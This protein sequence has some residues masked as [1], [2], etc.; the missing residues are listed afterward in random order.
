MLQLL[1]ANQRNAK[2]L[3]AE[4]DRSFPGHA[5]D[6]HRGFA[7]SL[8]SSQAAWEK[9]AEAQCHYEADKNFGGSGGWD[10]EAQCKDRLNRQRSAELQVLLATDRADG[11]ITRK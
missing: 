11:T 2:S 10:R 1:A 8:N 6:N 9:Y 4:Y 7:S 3:D 5:T